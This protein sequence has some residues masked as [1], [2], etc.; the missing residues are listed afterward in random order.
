LAKLQSY[1]GRGLYP[2]NL[3]P[4]GTI[5]VDRVGARLATEVDAPLLAQAF[6]QLV[7]QDSEAA[8]RV[9]EVK[10]TPLTWPETTA[11][12][13]ALLGEG[14]ALTAVSIT[15]TVAR[16]GDVVRV[17]VTWQVLTAPGGDFTTFVHLAEA[18]QPPLATGDSP[19]RG[20]HYPTRAWAADEVIEDE[21]TLT[22]PTGLADGRYPLWLGLYD[23]VTSGRLPVTVGGQP[24]PEQAYLLG[25]L[26]VGN[27][28]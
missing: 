11:E 6:V 1:H 22:V 18:G 4:Q 7:G 28:D 25:Y 16:P 8:L 5:V 24:Q 20:G 21:Y 19:P 2:A 10:V 23:P 15:P 26:Q 12:P 17:A 14:V 13:L 3:W 27:E 9:G